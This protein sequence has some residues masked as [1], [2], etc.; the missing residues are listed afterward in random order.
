MK[1]WREK[2]SLNGRHASQRYNETHT[3]A[4]LERKKQKRKEKKPADGTDEVGELV[5]KNA[6]SRY[7]L[8]QI[9]KIAHVTL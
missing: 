6:L 3:K 2:R 8:L 1:E 7:T 4:V 5:Q 9:V